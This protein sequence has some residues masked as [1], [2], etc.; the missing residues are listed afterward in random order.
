MEIAGANDKHLIA[1][2]FCRSLMGD[3]L[4]IQIIYK[5]ETTRCHPCFKKPSDMNITHSPKHWSTEETM[6]GYTIIIPYEHNLDIFLG[7][8]LIIA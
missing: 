5:G 3:F 8:Y 2:V 6:V 4:S 7:R 1:A